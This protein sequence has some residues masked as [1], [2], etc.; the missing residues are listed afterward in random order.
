MERQ[1][2]GEYDASAS[3]GKL[4]AFVNAM[5]TAGIGCRAQHCRGNC[6]QFRF[7]AKHRKE[8]EA[9]AQTYGVKLELTARRTLRQLVYRYRLRFGIPLGLLL[10]GGLLFYGSNIVMTIEVIGNETS[11]ETEILSIL[12]QQGVTRGSWIP[13]MDFTQC[14]HI[15]RADVEELAWVGIRHTGNRLVVEVME[16]EPEVEQLDTRVPCNVIAEQDAQIVSVSVYCGQLVPMVGDSVQKGALLISG[17]V[18]D[19]T[20]HAAVRHAMGSIIGIYEQQQTFTCPYVQQVRNPT[21]ES[22]TRRYL[23]LFAWHI[24][25]GSTEDPYTE[26]IQTTGYSWFSLF[27]A[28]LPVG[29]YRETYQEYR[30]HLLAFTP[31]EAQQN[32]EEQILRYEENFLSEAEILDKKTTALETEDGVE[33]TVTYTLQGEIGVQQDLYLQDQTD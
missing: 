29:I 8:V 12:A 6:Y 16:R 27:G 2:R 18:M 22:T 23:D 25:L 9:L 3:G 13:S 10:M 28:Q 17:V 4:Y 7:Y 24:P 1:L 19:E 31:E 5:H 32:L 30:T 26:S 20:G 21:G 14:E 15:L 11:T 33:W